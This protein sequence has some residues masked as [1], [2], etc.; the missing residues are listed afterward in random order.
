MTKTKKIRFQGHIY[1][2]VTITSTIP[3]SEPPKNHNI[4]EE[5]TEKEPVNK[6][7]ASDNTET[8]CI[9]NSEAST[10]DYPSDLDTL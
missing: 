4:T 3:P 5:N 9:D 7:T 10:E 2:S 8:H 6:V 1:S